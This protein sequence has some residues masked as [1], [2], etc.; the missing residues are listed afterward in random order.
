MPSQ[1]PIKHLLEHA[2]WCSLDEVSPTH[3]MSIINISYVWKSLHINVFCYNFNFW[4][5]GYEVIHLNIWKW[6]YFSSILYCEL[7][8]FFL[9]LIFVWN[10]L[11][12][13]GF[14]IEAD[15]NLCHI[16]ELVLNCLWHCSWDQINLKTFNHMHSINLVQFVKPKVWILK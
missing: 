9:W 1:N 11:S 7:F 10:Q 13:F 5:N 8:F 2:T 16:N 6:F 4:S 3:K 12:T 14:N 15:Y